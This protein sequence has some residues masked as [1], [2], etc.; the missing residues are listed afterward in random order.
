MYLLTKAYIHLNLLSSLCLF[1]II[2]S[3]QPTIFWIPCLGDLLLIKFVFWFSISKN[4]RLCSECKNSFVNV[5]RK[6]T[7]FRRVLFFFA[8]AIGEIKAIMISSY[9]AFCFAKGSMQGVSE[10][11][12]FLIFTFI[13]LFDNISYGFLK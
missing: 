9:P 8:G 12:P 2:V 7:F 1:Y 6:T 4:V 5:N 13:L 3:S 11:H 10:S